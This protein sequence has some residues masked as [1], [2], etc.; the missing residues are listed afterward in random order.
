[1][2]ECLLTQ[3]AHRQGMWEHF[4]PPADDREPVGSRNNPYQANVTENFECYKARGPP[5]DS[6]K[7][8]KKAKR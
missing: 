3:E 2:T 6:E 5:K 4:C 7:P 1:M 8:A